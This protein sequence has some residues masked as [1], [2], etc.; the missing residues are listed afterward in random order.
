MTLEEYKKKIK[1]VSNKRNSNIKDS[2][3]IIDGFLY[4]REKKKAEGK[5]FIKKHEY[6]LITRKINNILREKFS[7][8]EIDIILPAKLGTIELRKTPVKKNIVDG[9][10]VTTAMID[11]NK[12]LELWYEDQEAFDNRVL[13]KTNSNISFKIHYN[14]DRAEYIGKSYYDFFPNRELKNMLKKNIR[15]NKIDAYTY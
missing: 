6:F 8:A 9:K 4:Y 14:K 1:K 12:T 7:N 5:P 10:L 3:G 13:V 15:D 11:W 2:Y